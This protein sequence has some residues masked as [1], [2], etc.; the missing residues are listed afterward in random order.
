LALYY[1]KQIKS[2]KFHLP[3]FLLGK[4]LGRQEIKKSELNGIIR[5]IDKMTVEHKDKKRVFLLQN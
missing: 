2:Q 3:K 4:N 5:K 1:Y